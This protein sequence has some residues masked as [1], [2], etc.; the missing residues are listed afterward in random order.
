[1]AVSDA[2]VQNK[3]DAIMR[4]GDRDGDGEINFGE[5]FSSFSS[6]HGTMLKLPTNNTY[7]ATHLTDFRGNRVYYAKDLGG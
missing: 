1:M 5:I 2:Q 6:C 3:A 7:H 4:Q